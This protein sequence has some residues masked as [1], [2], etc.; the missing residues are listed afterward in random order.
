MHNFYSHDNLF[1][2]PLLP[3]QPDVTSRSVL[4][5][6]SPAILAKRFVVSVAPLRDWFAL[7]TDQGDSVPYTVDQDGKIRSWSDDMTDYTRC[8]CDSGV[9]FTP[10]VVHY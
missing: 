3:T 4:T 6:R 1:T 10:M 9:G 5:I 7:V 8:S 2:F